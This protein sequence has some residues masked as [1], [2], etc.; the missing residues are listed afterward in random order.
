MILRSDETSVGSDHTNRLIVTSV[1]IFQLV[2]S[3]TC[4]PGHQLITHTDSE[5]GLILS[6][7]LADILDRLRA[8]FRVTGTIRN[9]QSV[10]IYI[11]TIIVPWNA[12]ELHATV[13]ETSQ[14]IMLHTA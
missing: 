5:N 7:S 13:Y 8:E 9:E 4:S 2:G 14:D 3:S 12:D 10:I 6:H 1:A 11:Q